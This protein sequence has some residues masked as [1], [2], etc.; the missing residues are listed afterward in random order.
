MSGLNARTLR[1]YSGMNNSNVL[2]SDGAR[3]VAILRAVD[4]II[5]Q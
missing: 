4:G 1:K 2:R 5:A 3:S